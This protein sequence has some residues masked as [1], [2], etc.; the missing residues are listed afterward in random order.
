MRCRPEVRSQAPASGTSTRSS[1]IASAA[2]SRPWSLLPAWFA[3]I[4]LGLGREASS[5]AVVVATALFACSLAIG[6]AAFRRIR[7]LP[8]VVALEDGWLHIRGRHVALALPT[9]ALAGIEIGASAGLESVRLSTR[10]GRTLRLPGDLDDL[11]GFVD[12]LCRENPSIAVTDHR[13]GA[14]A[15]G[16]PDEADQGPPGP[17]PDPEPG[18]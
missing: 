10:Q 6:V 18:P 14:A 1:V 11:G 13:R 9:E 17:G 8:S 16:G 2:G 4:A 12:A 3:L 5:L 7:R 15:D